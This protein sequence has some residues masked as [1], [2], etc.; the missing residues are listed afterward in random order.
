MFEKSKNIFCKFLSKDTLNNITREQLIEIYK[1]LHSGD[2]RNSRFHSA[3]K[4]VNNNN[5]DTI[6][7]GLQY[8]LYS[9]DDIVLRID[10]LI[11]LDSKLKLEEFGPSCTQELIGWVFY[12]KYP[13]RND[14]ADFGVK[15]LGYKFDIT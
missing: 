3:E 2:E 12:D 8:L 1:N 14:K 15:F 6:K 10:S 7:K 5:L 11:S 4:F 9:N 13:M